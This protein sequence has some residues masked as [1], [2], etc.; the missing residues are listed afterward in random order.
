MSNQNPSRKPGTGGK[1]PSSRKSPASTSGDVSKSASKRK[2]TKKGPA[3][4]P[5]DLAVTPPPTPLPIRLPDPEPEIKPIK[6]PAPAAKPEPAQNQ[7]FEEARGESVSDLESLQN[8]YVAPEPSWKE[9]PVDQPPKPEFKPYVQPGSFKESSGSKNGIFRAIIILVLLVAGIWWFFFAPRAPKIPEE[10]KVLVTPSED[11]KATPH[12]IE[13]ETVF[14]E[15]IDYLTPRTIAPKVVIDPDM[16]ERT[17]AEPHRAPKDA[18]TEVRDLGRGTIT[19]SQAP[20]KTSEPAAPK[21]VP[22]SQA[23]TAPAEPLAARPAPTPV[24]IRPPRTW[25]GVVLVPEIARVSK[26]YSTKISLSRVE[27]HPQKNG[28]IH[29]W[30]RL[31]N[32]LSEPIIVEKDCRFRASGSHS[33]RRLGFQPVEIPANGFADVMFESSEPSIEEYTIMVRAAFDRSSGVFDD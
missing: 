30:V 18:T 25:S 29:V 14:P 24:Q 9:E 27:A 33:H 13:K 2:V 16:G 31:N 5:L 28:Y 6:L 15:S 11:N 20:A 17:V 26:L 19:T 22:A 7:V 4:N 10:A 3:S 21:T 23:T 8:S 12:K 1:K 32:L